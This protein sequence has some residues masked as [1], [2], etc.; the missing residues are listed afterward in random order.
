ME[1]NKT[2]NDLDK[3][4]KEIHDDFYQQQL[5]NLKSNNNVI[6][7][8][9]KKP[10][11]FKQIE[12]TTSVFSSSPGQGQQNNDIDPAFFFGANKPN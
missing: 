6:N 11:D 4:D 3:N 9:M 7:L 2:V 12:E 1:I 10:L 8:Q 5:N